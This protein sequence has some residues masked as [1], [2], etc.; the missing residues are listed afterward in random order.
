MIL[1]KKFTFNPFQ[2]N[3][4]LLINEEKEC[5]VIDPG[6]FNRSEQKE[7]SD[8]IEENGIKPIRLI[9]THAHIDHVLGNKFISEKYNLGLEL[10]QSEYDML[11]LAKRS[12]EVYGIP[13]EESPAPAAFIKDGEELLF[14]KSVLKAY[15]VPGHSPDH[16]VFLC[17]ED[18]F[19]IGGDVLFKGSIG[20]TDLPGGNHQQL[21]DN[22][23]SIL[24]KMDDEVIVYSGHGPETTIGEEKRT[25]PFF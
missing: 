20:R 23:S 11:S 16:L 6:C 10:F 25:N 21:L 4:Y 5:I 3:T 19:L 17:E 13:Y 18:Q 15:H 2:E 8:Y 1:I 9:C 22:I 12:S 24:F 14:G 7:L